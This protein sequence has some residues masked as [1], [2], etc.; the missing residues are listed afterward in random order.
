[1]VQT[2]ASYYG[3]QNMFAWEDQ[4]GNNH[5]ILFDFVHRIINYDS[6][7]CV[8]VNISLDKSYIESINELFNTYD[9]ETTPGLV[10]NF[11]YYSFK[12]MHNLLVD[13]LISLL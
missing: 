8:S 5:F 4:I 2:L 9:Y 13:K 3:L 12:T 1:M 11:E 7:A 10:S 6:K